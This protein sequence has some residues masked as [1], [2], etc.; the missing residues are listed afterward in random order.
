MEAVRFDNVKYS[1]RDGGAD[2]AVNGVTLS[3]GEGEFVAVLG[4]NGCGI[5][6]GQRRGGQ[7]LPAM[8]FSE[9]HGRGEALL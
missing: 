2:F 7:Y 3:V 8:V 4:R 6:H 9:N 1:Y 5:F